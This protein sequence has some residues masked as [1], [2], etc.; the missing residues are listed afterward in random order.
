MNLD[1]GQDVAGGRVHP[2]TPYL[3]RQVIERVGAWRATARGSFSGAVNAF[4]R[5]LRAL[6]PGSHQ[7]AVQAGTAPTR[8]RQ[9]GSPRLKKT[10][11]LRA[12]NNAWVAECIQ[13]GD[14][15]AT[16]LA[17]LL[18]EAP[19]SL[20]PPPA[21]SDGTSQ[22]HKHGGARARAG[23]TLHH[24]D[25]PA[26]NATLSE[27]ALARVN[28]RLLPEERF[29]TALNR[30]V[31][32]L[33]AGTSPISG[34]PT[35]LPK[36]GPHQ[37]VNA[38][39]RPETRTRVKELSLPGEAWSTALNRLLVALPSRGFILGQLLALLTAEETTLEAAL[40]QAWNNPAAQIGRLLAASQEQGGEN[41]AQQVM[42]TLAASAF[43]L[44]LSAEEGENVVAGWASEREGTI[45]LSDLAA[46]VAAH[47]PRPDSG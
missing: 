9:R 13:T 42:G 26:R 23:R 7:S 18:E 22:D 25:G 47:G 39:F 32:A 19:P 4:L 45:G 34:T 20:V 35:P 6:D 41:P 24:S 43:T 38:Y 33:P 28:E 17:R 10:V 15:T 27:L 30:I 16:A 2:V 14:T 31:A 1:D 12:D 8:R 40:E 36:P 3:S 5:D 44:P 29:S 46:F 11:A 37:Q 21:T